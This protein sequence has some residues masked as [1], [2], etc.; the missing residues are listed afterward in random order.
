VIEAQLSG[1]VQIAEY[2]SL[3]YVLAKEKGA[4]IT[5][6]GAAIDH[7]GETPG[8]RSYGIT[9]AGSPIKSIKDYAGKKVC[10]VDPDST[11]GYLYPSAVLLPNGINPMTEVLPTFAGGH[12]ASA[13]GAGESTRPPPPGTKPGGGGAVATRAPRKGDSRTGKGR[14]ADRGGAGQGAS[15]TV[16]GSPTPG[17]F[18]RLVTSTIS[19]PTSL[20]TTS[21]VTAPRK[22]LVSTVPGRPSGSPTASPS[23]RT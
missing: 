11:S 12:D 7:K 23:G 3:S 10:F 4:D 1:Q 6:V 21:R 22:V 14:L 16:V 17:R 9:K 19:S 13:E 20:E 2:G 5:A 8:Y 18:G 15:V